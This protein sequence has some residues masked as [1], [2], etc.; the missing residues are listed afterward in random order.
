MTLPA[1]SPGDGKE[2]DQSRARSTS[3]AR[4]EEQSSHLRCII[5]QSEPLLAW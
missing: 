2:K 4:P 1:T 3:S 5:Q